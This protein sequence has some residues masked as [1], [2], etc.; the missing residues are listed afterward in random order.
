MNP[1]KI[2][3]T[4]IDGVILDWS[5]N[6]PFYLSNMKMKTDHIVDLLAN[7]NTGEAHWSPKALFPEAKTDD[8]ALGLLIGYCQSPYMATLSSWMDSLKVVNELVA[9]GYK[10]VG[11]TALVN[12]ELTVARRKANI[13]ALFPGA[14]LEIVHVGVGQSKEEA[15]TK[16]FD[17]YGVPLCYIDDRLVHLNEYSRAIEKYSDVGYTSWEFNLIEH[18]LELQP[19]CDKESRFEVNSWF[20][21]KNKILAIKSLIN[22]NND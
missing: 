20:D 14:F 4:D 2:I 9:E 15:F 21:I 7:G 8:S 17:K 19:V 10:F 3:F 16:L 5:S 1:D 6:L 12:D 13:D 22:Y 11:V 18:T